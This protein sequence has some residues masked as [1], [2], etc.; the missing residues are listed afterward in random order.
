M[1]PPFLVIK[2]ALTNQYQQQN[3]HKNLPQTIPTGLSQ[4]G[5]I[6]THRLGIF[7]EKGTAGV[8]FFFFSFSGR[9]RSTL[10][11]GRSWSNLASSQMEEGYLGWLA[12]TQQWR[13]NV[14]LLLG[15]FNI[16]GNLFFAPFLFPFT[17]RVGYTPR[18]LRYFF[19]FF[20]D[21]GS[22]LFALCSVFF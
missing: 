17:I 14:E 10:G 20:D 5:D 12:G 22:L 13:A 8:R 21:C 19:F 15:L 1:M 18:L 16:S 9:V 6:T 2:Y 11:N 4:F 3:Q 7:S